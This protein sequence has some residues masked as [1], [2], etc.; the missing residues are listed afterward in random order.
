MLSRFGWYT[1]RIISAIAGLAIGLGGVWYVG[2][3]PWP[4]SVR[5]IIDVVLIGIAA[6]FLAGPLTYSAYHKRFEQSD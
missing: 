4:G 3:Q 5:A 2:K 1:L 6:A